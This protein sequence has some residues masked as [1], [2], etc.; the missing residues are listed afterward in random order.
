MAWLAGGA[1][2]AVSGSSV[3]KAQ[4]FRS[5]SWPSPPRP[6]SPRLLPGRSYKNRA[7]LILQHLVPILLL[8]LLVQSSD[9]SQTQQQQQ[10]QTLSP[11]RFHLGSEWRSPQVYGGR[12]DT[13]SVRLSP[14]AESNPVQEI[15]RQVFRRGTPTWFW[16]TIRSDQTGPDQLR[17]NC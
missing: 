12:G 10:Q 6:A 16:S 17:F 4:S 13:T 3:T 7:A 14:A 8:L 11:A 5:T 9:Q 2:E 15:L 1:S